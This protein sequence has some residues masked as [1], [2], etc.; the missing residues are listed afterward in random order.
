MTAHDDAVKRELARQRINADARELLRVELREREAAQLRVPESRLDLA[1]ELLI[2]EQPT[3]WRIQDLLPMDTN[4]TV[5]AQFKT[6]KTTLMLNLMR[7]LVDGEPFLGEFAVH[8]VDGRVAYWNFEL[9]ETMWRRWAR[10]VDMHKL[11]RASVNHVAGYHI[12]LRTEVGAD[13]AAEWLRQRD[14]EVWILDPFHSAFDGDENSNSEV[15]DWLRAVEQIGSRA[16]L[17]QIVMPVHTGR[18]KADEGAERARGATRLDDWTD[19][20]WTY[21]AENGV[22]FLAASGRDVDFNVGALAYD[23][24]SRRLAYGTGK[25]R[26]ET[27]RDDFAAHIEHLAEV[28]RE[29]AVEQPGLNVEQLRNAMRER[30]EHMQRSDANA[31]S[32]CAERKSW[33]Q[34]KRGPNNSKLHYPPGL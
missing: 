7:S 25:S 23:P 3:V 1:D 4:L 13:Y 29:I 31:A 22:R 11:D 15:R 34:V 9:N 10:D 6:G 12:D 32:E 19:V 20:R 24:G 2:P 16:E 30:G 17:R 14:T 27:R 18:A 5:A 26:T 21:T 28:V 33:V 8:R